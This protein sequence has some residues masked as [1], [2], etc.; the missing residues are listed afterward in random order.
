M[1]AYGVPSAL[2]RIL[3]LNAGPHP[4]RGTVLLLREAIGF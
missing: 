3:I 1:K 2:N 4:R